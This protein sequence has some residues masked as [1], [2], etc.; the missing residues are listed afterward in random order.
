VFFLIEL[1]SKRLYNNCKK[2][3]GGN[4]LMKRI[5]SLLAVSALAVSL[6]SCATN[7]FEIA[8]I[9]DL[10]S[11]DDKSFNQGT[12]EGVNQYAEDNNKTAKYYQPTD[13]TTAAY[14]SA[15]D[16][17]VTGGAKIVVTPGFLFI[18]AIT[19]A[20][21]KYP[22][23]KFVLIDAAPAGKIN[24]NTLSVFFAEEE[25]G[26]LAGYAAVRD[27]FEKV[28]FMGGLPVPAV[29]K[30]GLGFVAGVYYAAKEMNK[31][32]TVSI[33]NS[34]FEYLGTFGPSDTVK[35]TAS[36]W[37]NAG[38]ELIFAAAGGA[39]GSV[40]A[41]ASDGV[42]KKVIG[43]DVNQ[44]DQSATVI[45]SAM[46]EIGTAA[47]DAIDAFYS[48]KWNGGVSQV[49]SAANDGVGL[50]DDFSRF[51]TFNKTQY[52]VIFAKL[53]NKT[54]VVPQT[55]AALR[56]FVSD[57]GINVSDVNKFPTALN[58]DASLG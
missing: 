22:D 9:T 23:I 11:I 36:G 3:I 27:G 25:S 44:K 18:G 49:F 42:N 2:Y 52:D 53:A 33:P 19:E 8:M 39:G 13:A 45:T 24:D 30:F 55:Y 43:V 10:G 41:A 28:G 37:Y 47:Y 17:A 57:L 51:R 38:T 21:D 31:L 34:R 40:M 16:L 1:N 5:L 58:A 35:S 7:T 32:N 50:P 26:F 54:I 14:V 4:I 48:N 20:Q 56:T 29:K 12:W 6:S 46:K 15:I